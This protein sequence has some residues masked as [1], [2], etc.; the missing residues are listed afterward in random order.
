MA[1]KVATNG[2]T[3]NGDSILPS[4]YWSWFTSEVVSKG[5]Q[6][7]RKGVARGC[8]GVARGLQRDCKGAARGLQ[9]VDC[10]T[11]GSVKHAWYSTHLLVGLFTTCFG[12]CISI[13]RTELPKKSHLF[14]VGLFTV[15]TWYG[16]GISIERTAFAETSHTKATRKHEQI[17]SSSH[18]RTWHQGYIY[19][20]IY[21]YVY[22]HIYIYQV[23]FRT[24]VPFRHESLKIPK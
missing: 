4:V 13:E 6:G 15:N 14:L 24:A 1:I 2:V 12:V 18:T 7:G 16:T 5:L 19:I 22:I 17:F 3:V 8:E 10:I 23:C 20:Y 11:P 21:I 9:G